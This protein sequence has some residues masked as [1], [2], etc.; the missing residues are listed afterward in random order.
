MRVTLALFWLALL[1]WF[2]ATVAPGVA[3]AGAFYVIPRLEITVPALLP[4]F[5]GDSAEAGR[6]VAGRTLQPIFDITG[7]V[8]MSAAA[9]AVSTI[10][11]LWRTRSMAAPGWPTTLT[12]VLVLLGG[13]LLAGRIV[14]SNMQR[15]DLLAYWQGVAQLDRTMA[16]PAKER[17]DQAH[18]TAMRLSTLQTV[19]LLATVVAGA[20]ACTPA[21]RSPQEPQA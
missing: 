20:L 6:Y 15:A 2:T 10:I 18:A 1:V 16:L 5:G 13:A 17:F 9:L 19:L 21:P 4:Y 12:L 7:W 8:Q 11:R 14:Q 3:A